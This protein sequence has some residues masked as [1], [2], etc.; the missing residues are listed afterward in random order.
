M[1]RIKNWLLNIRFFWE[2]N[3]MPILLWLL[4]P[5]TFVLY[6]VVFIRIGTEILIEANFVIADGLNNIF[7]VSPII[8]FDLN[9]LIKILI[10]SFL[11]G[12]GGWLLLIFLNYKERNF[13]G[14]CGI[15]CLAIIYASLFSDIYPN[16][17][18]HNFPDDVISVNRLIMT[19]I[20]MP[21]LLIALWIY[22]RN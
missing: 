3:W 21:S 20:F 6:L 4:M 10:G 17:T 14:K 18:E 11:V 2:D 7:K 8:K 22:Y 5:I 9:V 12:L 1:K 15:G 16:F 13:L 19:I